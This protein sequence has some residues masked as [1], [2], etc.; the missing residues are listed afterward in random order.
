M[1][2]KLTKLV[3]VGFKDEKFK[4][5]IGSKEESTFTM[6]MNPESYSFTISTI[7]CKPQV[8]ANSETND[9]SLKPDL[10]NLELNFYLDSTGVVPGCSSVP[11]SLAKFHK[12]CTEINGAIHTANYLKVYWGKGLA[13]PCRLKSVT[14]DYLMFKPNGEPV[15]VQVKAKLQEFVDAA[16]NAAANNNNSPDMTHLRTVRAGDNLPAMCHE[17]YGDTS[18]YIQVAEHNKIL[19]FKQLTPG[20]EIHFPRMRK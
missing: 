17:I 12:I 18:L 20:T 11:D 14:V 8:Q 16:T 9:K 15:R 10:K 3:I 6:Q 13:F 19:N 4:T 5:K 7:N 2:G 1:A